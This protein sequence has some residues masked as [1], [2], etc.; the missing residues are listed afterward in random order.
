MV[1]DCRHGRC[2]TFRV[3]R[4]RLSICKDCGAGM[5]GER[6]WVM[7]ANR[8]AEAYCAHASAWSFCAPRVKFWC[9]HCGHLELRKTGTG[10]AHHQGRG[11]FDAD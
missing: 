7:P 9:S 11:R 5:T 6:P 4:G 2:R 10:N 8:G 1:S 3:E